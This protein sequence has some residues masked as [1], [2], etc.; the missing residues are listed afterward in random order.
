MH[1]VDGY[2]DVFRNDRVMVSTSSFSTVFAI[3]DLSG[4]ELHTIYLVLVLIKLFFIGLNFPVNYECCL[5]FE[6]CHLH[7]KATIK[8]SFAIGNFLMSTGQG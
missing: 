5:I 3:H 8:N 1:C 6:P 7:T 4:S 2:C